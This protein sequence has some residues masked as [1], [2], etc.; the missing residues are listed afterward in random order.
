MSLIYDELVQYFLKLSDQLNIKILSAMATKLWI[1]TLMV[2]LQYD[3]WYMCA[4]CLETEYLCTSM[5]SSEASKEIVVRPQ[6]TFQIFGS[7]SYKA[8]IFIFFH[9]QQFLKLDGF[10]SMN[11][12]ILPFLVNNTKNVSMIV[13][14]SEHISSD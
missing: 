3:R 9:Q 7:Q 14:S 12:Q 8:L 6:F 11:I 13:S 1:C 5:L 10:S 2:L 4:F